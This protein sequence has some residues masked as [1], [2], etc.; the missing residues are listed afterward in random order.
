MLIPCTVQ[1]TGDKRGILFRKREALIVRAGAE[2]NAARCALLLSFPK[3]EE[4]CPPL[5]RGDG[6][7]R[8]YSLSQKRIPPLSGSSAKSC[9]NSCSANGAAT[10]HP[11]E[12]RSKGIPSSRRE[13]PLCLAVALSA[14]LSMQRNA[15]QPPSPAR[16]RKSPS[17]CGGKTLNPEA[18][19]C[20][21]RRAHGSAGAARSVPPA[22]RCWTRRGSSRCPFPW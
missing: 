15:L 19:S 21:G 17:P 3:K 22:R 1:G 9:T 16:G 11:H 8:G 13:Y 18:R 20:R 2:G 7:Q 5:Y 6:R 14:A 4:L 12:G 10:T